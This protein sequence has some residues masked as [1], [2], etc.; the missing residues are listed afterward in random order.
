ML[1]GVL[2]VKSA[3]SKRCKVAAFALFALFALFF[4]SATRPF[5]CKYISLVVNVLFCYKLVT[6]IV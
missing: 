1:K 3:W 2:T 4:N 5:D 6:A